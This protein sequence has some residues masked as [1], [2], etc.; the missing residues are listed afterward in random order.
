M[1]C[2]AIGLAFAA[3][4]AAQ[5]E[6]VSVPAGNETTTDDPESREDVRDRRVLDTVVVK[7]TR[8]DTV[9]QD[10]PVSVRVVTG[11]DIRELALQN[12]DELSSYVPGLS[13][14]EG[15]EQTSVSIRG[16]G[17][18]VNFGFDQSAG[19]FIDGIYA[20]RER[21]FRTAFLDIGAVEVLRGPQAALF[22]KN[23]TAGAIIISTGQPTQE[24]SAD[25]YAQ[26]T[27][28]I[29]LKY[30]QAILNGGLTDNLSARLALRYSDQ[31]G[32]MFN[33]FTNETEEQ[34]EDIAGRLTL[35][36]TP[37][38]R[39]SVRTK[40]EASH[41]ER[42]GR[43]F[44][45]SEVSGLQT[46]RP[47]INAA[48]LPID[49]DIT[50]RLSTYLAYDPD[51][52]FDNLTQN[53]K[54]KETAS[55]NSKNAAVKIE[56]EFP[57]EYT[58]T[59]ITGYSGYDSED[60]RDIDWGPTNFLFEP[61][62]QEFNQ[63]SQ[64][65]QILSPSDRRFEFMLGAHAFK[66]DFYVDRRTD[67]DINVFL[68]PF[69]AVPFDPAPFGGRADIWRFANLRFLDQDTK[70]YSV[71]GSGTFKFNDAW[72]L[73]GGLRYNKE[74]KTSTDRLYL[75]EFGNSRF[76]DPDNNPEDAAQIAAIAAVLGG[77]I[78]RSL[79][80]ARVGT[81]QT[82]SEDDWS[83]EVTLGYKLNDDASF[84]ARLTEGHKGGGFNAQVT[85]ATGARTFEPEKVTGYEL[86][87][88]LRLLDDTASFN[89]ALF[90]QDYENLQTSVWNGE[91]FDVGNAG[92]ARSQGL[93]AD[94]KWLIG[95]RLELNGSVAWIDARY[96][97]DTTGS[98]SV[99]QRF[100][101]APGCDLTLLPTDPSAPIPTAPNAQDLVGQRF[102]PTISATFGAAY[103]LPLGENHEVLLRGDGV[104]Y[105]RNF[106][107]AGAQDPS[108][109][110]DAKTLFDFGATL[111]PVDAN[112]TLGFLVQNVTD[113]EFY[114]YEFEA[115]G[116]QIGTR[117]GFPGSPRRF[118]VRGSISF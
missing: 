53:S 74:D 100:F 85:G 81:K 33:T 39:L 29:D 51:F 73:T 61:I 113:K 109:I 94:G 27:S 70:S 24:Y 22:G 50:A 95:D 12:L 46:G 31:Q 41:Y 26:Y 2:T 71:Y 98:C 38:D 45:F 79:L 8:R 57:N 96:I 20:G 63:Y 106:S 60:Q 111:R 115:P 58:L 62:T 9:L 65:F 80:Q 32:Y 108:V 47:R 104:H 25:L 56:Y 75:S 114:W 64:E 101:G 48:G 54:Q 40:L 17:S 11:E 82:L 89:F 107:A 66:N 110:Q 28:E 99:S 49:T 93:E 87:G 69:G 84:Y 76:L 18:G 103:V 37:T 90:R 102:A 77:D 105:G 83:P 15:G 97:K 78:S 92:T 34:E 72:S 43:A 117:V 112:W 14:S 35:L 1:A 30:T 36:W 16:F 6:P 13:I 23:T 86:G 59:S 55:V 116:P 5:E 118:T 21:Q 42:D 67:V 44:N 4:V 10:V 88:K 19:M 68:L 7:A 3:P 52:E 91:I